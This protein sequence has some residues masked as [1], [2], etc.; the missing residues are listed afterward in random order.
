MNEKKLEQLMQSDFSVGTEAFRDALL[1]RCL[2]VLNSDEGIPLS[3]SELELL[4]AAGDPCYPPTALDN[5]EN[6]R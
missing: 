4:S 6:L 5:R 3:E 2:S 1:E